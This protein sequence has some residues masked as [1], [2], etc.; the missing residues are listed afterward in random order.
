MKSISIYA[1]TRNQNIEC[2]QKLER[3]LSGR[4]YFLKMREWELESMKALVRELEMHMQDV[5]ALRFFYSFQVPRL[6]KEFDL[7]QIKDDQIVNI[8][9]KSGKVS[10]EAVRKQLL[11][12]RYYLSVQGK[13]IQSY[14]YISSQERLVRLNN[15]DHIVEADWDQLCLALQRQSKDYEGDIEDL[16]QAEMY[17]FSPV[18]EPERFLN[19]E[20]F[21]TSQ[22]KDIE[23]RILDKIRKVKYGYF[24]FSGLPGTGKT[25]L[26]YDIAMKLSVHQKVC[27]IHCGETGKEWKILH[28]RLLRIAFLSDSQLEEGP[29]LKEYRA[30]LVDEA[31]LLSVKELHRILELSEKHP[32]IFSGDD[33]D[34]ISDEEMD[35][36][37][38]REIEH[39]PDIQSFHLTNRIRTNAELSSFIQN[40][41]HLP[42]KRMVRYY[43]HIQVV[44]ANDEE[45]AEIL[46]KGYQ[47]QLVFIID[48]RYYYDEKG[49]LREQR[50][51]QQKPTAVRML[52]H[53]LNEAREEFAIIVKRNEAVYEV[54]L[55]L[56]QFSKKETVKTIAE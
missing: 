38:L 42:E 25:L 37:M 18:T 45:E 51:K 9:L 1:I 36:T 26:L 40:M 13:M 31:H 2:L 55:E 56:L 17:L 53:R 33:E 35:R 19:K 44:Y 46:L 21:L 24:W 10:D 50:Q 7:L 49:Y 22:Q 8:E 47:D 20:Y 3:Q 52:F 28:D 12:N 5:H 54:L 34:M 30:I 14:T 32:V 43:P 27:M 39:L 29:D 16:F 15:H 48:E 23:R 41:M 6:G 4:T 11:Q